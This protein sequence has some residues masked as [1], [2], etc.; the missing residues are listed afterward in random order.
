MKKESENISVEQQIQ[1]G[2]NKNVITNIS[3][4]FIKKKKIIKLLLL[5]K[6]EFDTGKYIFVLL[7]YNLLSVDMLLQ[8]ATI[9]PSS[10]LC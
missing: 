2:Y 5:I 7:N 6:C 9:L 1:G 8:I 10:T 4:L 3:R